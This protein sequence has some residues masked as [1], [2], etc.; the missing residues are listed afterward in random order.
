M[1]NIDDLTLGQAKEIQRISH[2]Q[3]KGLG[4]DLIGKFCIFRCTDAGV[5]CGVLH[6]RDGRQVLSKNS[7]RIWRWSGANTLSE[8]SL[9]GADSSYTR[10]SE[11]VESCLLTEVC[12]I[13]LCSKSSKENLSK[14]RW[15]E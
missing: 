12:E 9:T 7:R 8:L 14:S 6:S 2:T 4:Y 11:P 5:H 15:G 3:S 13:I 1:I 10:I